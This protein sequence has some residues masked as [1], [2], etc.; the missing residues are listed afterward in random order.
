MTFKGPFQLKTFY[1]FMIPCLPLAACVTFC[2]P[3]THAYLVWILLSK[4]HICF[5][6]FISPLQE[7]VFMQCIF[8]YINFMS[9]WQRKWDCRSLPGIQLGRWWKKG[10]IPSASV[11][12]LQAN[13][14]RYFYFV[15]SLDRW[16]WNTSKQKFSHIKELKCFSLGQF[17]LKL[18]WWEETSKL[19]Y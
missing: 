3:D 5:M 16:C 18:H 10:K 9:L 7:T 2:K 17:H 4:G 19:W 15:L 8:F 1:D 13:F 12:R 11:P 6:L 14:P